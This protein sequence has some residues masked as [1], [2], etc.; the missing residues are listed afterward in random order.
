MESSLVLGQDDQ[1]VKDRFAGV[2]FQFYTDEEIEKISVLRVADPVA[3]DQLNNATKTG[4]HAPALGVSPFDHKSVCP[5]CGMTVT[6]CPGHLG[7]I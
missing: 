5:T 6:Q 1:A 4:L 3:F 2:Q 7:H